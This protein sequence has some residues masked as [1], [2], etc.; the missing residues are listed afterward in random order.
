MMCSMDGSVASEG[1]CSMCEWLTLSICCTSGE[2]A[3]VCP[4]I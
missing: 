1:M 2:K 3:A 4:R